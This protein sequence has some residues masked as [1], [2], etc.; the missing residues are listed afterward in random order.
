[1]Y[2]RGRGEGGG[3]GGGRE[4][5]GEREMGGKLHKIEIY[6][7]SSFPIHSTTL[8]YLTTFT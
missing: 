8:F 1:M 4:K 2:L 3:E 5:G 6:T 7:C